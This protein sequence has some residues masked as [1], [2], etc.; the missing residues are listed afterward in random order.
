MFNI[1]I[2]YNPNLSPDIIAVR[3]RLSAESHGTVAVEKLLKERATRQP[4]PHASI[5]RPVGVQE[6]LIEYLQLIQHEIIK[7]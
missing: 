4:H 2:F 7:S 3:I 1:K 5:D 6:Q